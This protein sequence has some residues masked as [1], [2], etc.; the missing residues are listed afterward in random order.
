MK[1][2]PAP[3]AALPRTRPRPIPAPRVSRETLLAES[4]GITV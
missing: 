1:H 2:G 4:I 3:D